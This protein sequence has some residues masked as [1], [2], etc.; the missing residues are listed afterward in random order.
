M[1]QSAS[2]VATGE[3]LISTLEGRSVRPLVGGQML[4]TTGVA[5]T[6]TFDRQR[7]SSGTPW[8]STLWSPAVS[9][10]QYGG[11]WGVKGQSRTTWPSTRIW[12][13][14]QAAGVVRPRSKV[15]GPRNENRIPVAPVRRRAS[16]RSHRP[17]VR[18]I[19]NSAVRTRNTT[20]PPAL[21]RPR[22]R[23]SCPNRPVW[24]AALCRGSPSPGRY[25]AGQLRPGAP[26]S[27]INDDRHVGAVGDSA[28]D[29]Q[30]RRVARP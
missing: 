29:R 13:T 14:L 21:P 16:L 24:C 27:F 20:A 26:R 12:I 9:R 17:P 10:S 19:G 2:V 23:A 18:R 6:D 8:I 7:T 5:S 22:S 30:A 15:D 28:D 3:P 1:R 11:A 4:M 25:P